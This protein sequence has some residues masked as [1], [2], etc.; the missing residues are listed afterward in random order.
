MDTHRWG[1]LIGFYLGDGNIYIDR[2]RYDYRLR[3]F[4]NHDDEEIIDRLVIY[5]K[6]WV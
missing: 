4:I 5:L 1:Y 6:I 3:F 2:R